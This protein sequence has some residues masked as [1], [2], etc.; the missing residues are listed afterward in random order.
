MNQQLGVNYSPVMTPQGR[1][2][3]GCP[4]LGCHCEYFAFLNVPPPGFP[5]MSFDVNPPPGF[6]PRL[7]V[8]NRQN[9]AMS[10]AAEASSGN[11]VANRPNL[12]TTPSRLEEFS[13]TGSNSETTSNF[14]RFSQR[15][16][17]RHR[18]NFPHW[19]KFYGKG[20]WKPF[21]LQWDA[22][23]KLQN[24][25]EEGK[26]LCL[27]ACIKG[28]AAD[29][30]CDLDESIRSNFVKLVDALSFIYDIDA[31]K[32]VRECTEK[33]RHA[34]QGRSS[35][36]KF[37]LNVS[38][39]ANK[40]L[41]D[42]DNPGKAAIEAGEAFI[43]GVNNKK[44][45]DWVKFLEDPE[46]PRGLPLKVAVNNYQRILYDS[47]DMY[48]QTSN[49]PVVDIQKVQGEISPTLKKGNSKP[50]HAKFQGRRL[51]NKIVEI[52]HGLL[53]NM[54]KNKQGQQEAVEQSEICREMHSIK[55]IV[56]FAKHMLLAVEGGGE[57]TVPPDPPEKSL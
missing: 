28:D 36:Q 24:I 30:V 54:G 33:L 10:F 17:P 41:F 26:V 15:Q 19:P 21:F 37:A 1:M 56:D 40:A 2:P 11:Q 42:E 35:I 52:T 20:R 27:I 57:M 22:I 14:G 3:L 29:Y 5:A 46:Y 53:E 55:T 23:A 8:A 32:S 45:A 50:K 6:Q 38:T 51:K 43:R 31:T 18:P 47:G 49:A 9:P 4:I 12:V 44:C 13:D 16:P 48:P 25:E 7:L 34:K 39:L